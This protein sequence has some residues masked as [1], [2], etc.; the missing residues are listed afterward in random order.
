MARHKDAFLVNLWFEVCGHDEAQPV[1]WRGSVVHLMT[2]ERRYF[3]EIV[4]LVA[5]LTAYTPKTASKT[6]S[7]VPERAGTHQE[8]THGGSSIHGRA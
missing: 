4:D 7:D 6:A 5:F 2:Q 1:A 3:I 8:R